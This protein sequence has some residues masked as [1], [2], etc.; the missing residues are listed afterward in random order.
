MMAA[1]LAAAGMLRTYIAPFATPA[2]ERANGSR[3][4]PDAI[5]RRVAFELSR[6]AVPDSI[7]G[8]QIRHRSSVF[9]AA[10]VIAA[11]YAVSERA[12]SPLTR[13]RNC[14]FDRNVARE[15]KPSDQILIGDYAS[16]IR[17]IRRS[18]QLGITSFLNAPIAHYGF[19]RRLLAE[20]ARSVPSC[21]ATLP[22]NSLPG[23]Y[24]R[25]M[26]EELA[27]ADY[28]IVPSRF[29]AR[30]FIE[31]GVSKERL[32]V[33]PLGVDT[34]LFAPGNRPERKAFRV[35]FVGQLN[36]QKGLSYMLSAFREA[37][38]PKAELVLAGR[39]HGNAARLARS[40]GARVLGP[41]PRATLPRLYRASD[42]CV[43]PSLAEGFGL[44]ALE[45]MACGLPTIVSTNTFADDV[46]TD[47]RNGFVVPIREVTALAKRLA[48]L[49][50]DEEMRRRMGAEARATAEKLSWTAYGRRLVEAVSMRVDRSEAQ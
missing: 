8:R 33:I 18:S 3:F 21:L 6:R 22:L 12:V 17:A 46:I 4:L 42:V 11:R 30:T 15:L 41:V 19:V 20:E 27:L 35:L 23:W 10:S 34:T 16:A 29:A 48:L 28:I 2:S 50:S 39:P 49:H 24:E 14:W 32:V 26:D 47:S 43:L 5:R 25:A 37:D 44:T 1:G 7:D 36:Q 40:A 13:I 31:F 38:L 45:A 9:E